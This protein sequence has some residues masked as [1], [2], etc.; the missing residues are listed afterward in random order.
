MS[1]DSLKVRIST[2]I[3]PILPGRGFFQVEEDELY[4]Q[5]GPFSKK[6]RFFSYLESDDV[7]FDIDRQGR[8]IF[9]EVARA[10]RRWQVVPQLNPPRIIE[11]ASI[12][13]LGFRART[14]NPLLLTVAGRTRL[15][16]Q[17]TD[18]THL[19]SYFLA[20]SVVAQVDEYD[21]LAAV[22]ITD[23]SDDRAGHRMAAFRRQL[24]GK[25]EPFS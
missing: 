14:S 8:L 3:E 5:V 1:S 18:R 19:K 17:Y 12:R 9:I 13:W 7:R 11:A 20:E 25:P 6:R 10:S 21:R 2:P 16:I 4:V 15:L 24:R 23:I 22:W